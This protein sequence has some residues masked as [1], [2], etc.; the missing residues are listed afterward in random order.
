MPLKRWDTSW[1]MPRELN[2][3]NHAKL[4]CRNKRDAAYARYGGRGIKFRYKS[5]E[6]FIKDLGPRPMGL[7]LDRIN[8]D[9][10]YEP[11]NC[12]WATWSQQ[13]Y[14]KCQT[15]L[16]DV[17]ALR[18]AAK[19]DVSQSFLAAQFHV[20]QSTVSRVLSG[21]RRLKCPK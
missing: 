12:R 20:H 4:R 8:N 15:K 19:R 18:K 1:G 3:Y 2:S 17:N 14:N 10:N 11:G 21:K 5:F 7:T 6:E 13:A 9:G 16:L